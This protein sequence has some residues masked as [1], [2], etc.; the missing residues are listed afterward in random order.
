MMVNGPCDFC[1]YL[2]TEYSPLSGLPYM[3]HENHK[4]L[5]HT[6]VSE[7]ETAKQK[8]KSE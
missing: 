8:A 1:P 4:V 2:Y 6:A 7:T 3:L 5:T